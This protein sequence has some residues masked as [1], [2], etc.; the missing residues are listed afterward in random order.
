MQAAC[1]FVKLLPTLDLH[2]TQAEATHI[3]VSFNKECRNVLH[4]AMYLAWV[5]NKL[6]LWVPNDIAR[7]G[8]RNEIAHRGINVCQELLLCMQKWWVTCST[9]WS[10]GTVMTPGYN[11]LRSSP[12]IAQDTSTCRLLEQASN[13]EASVFT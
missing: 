11:G 13:K 10:V 5:P 12:A 7:L 2:F 1:D 9:V 6:S 4:Y 3:C 8:A